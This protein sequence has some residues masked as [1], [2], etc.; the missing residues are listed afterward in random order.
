MRSWDGKLR[1]FEKIETKK[2]GG[3]QGGK[4]LNI[5]WWFFR[6]EGVISRHL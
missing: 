1:C 5:F 4:L 3:S 2:L 6:R